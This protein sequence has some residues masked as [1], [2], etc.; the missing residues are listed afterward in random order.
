MN[1][2]GQKIA[3]AVK[4]E[5]E[6][7][8]LSVSELARRSGVSKATV[9]QLESSGGNP[10]V[11]TLWALATALGLPFA[12]LI[13]EH[14]SAPT[15]VR[16]AASSG[17]HSSEA[18]YTA[19]LLAVSPP[20]TRRDVYVINAEPGPA[21]RSEPHPRGTTEH[22]VMIAGEAR[23]GP[24]VAPYTLATGDYLSYPGDEPHIFEA[25]SPGTSAVLISEMR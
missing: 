7:A 1:N 17:I 19:T 23:V 18:T 11:E 5:R 16:R 10:S 4:R 3:R 12:A 13:E 22:V 20:Q 8:G 9:S 6:A 14:S 21:R 2:L 25:L 15:L 24:I